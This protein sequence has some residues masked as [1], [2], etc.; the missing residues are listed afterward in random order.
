MDTNIN[1]IL[2]SGENIVWQG[3]INRKVLATGLVISLV[4]ILVIGGFFFSKET[5]QYTSNGQAGQVSG[6]IVGMIIIGLGAILSLLAFFQNLVKAYTVTP[7]RVVIKSGIIGTDYQSI[8]FEQMKEVLVNV[9]LIGK[10]FGVG[11]IK[12]DTGKTETYSTGGTSIQHSGNMNT[13]SIRTRT[14][15]TYLSNIDTPYDVYKYVNDAVTERKE[16]LYSGRA[17]QQNIGQAKI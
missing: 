16:S 8:Y 13:Q 3:V 10:I 11:T 14:M 6:A 7:K 4:V 5:I 9:G 15:Y 1:S 12:I 2:Q 17:D